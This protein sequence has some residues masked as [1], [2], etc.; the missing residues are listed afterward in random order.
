MDALGDFGSFPQFVVSVVILDD[1]GGLFSRNKAFKKE[2]GENIGFELSEVAHVIR[3]FFFDIPQME[4]T[5]RS[6][7]KGPNAIELRIKGLAA[8]GSESFFLRRV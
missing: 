3:C 4:R 1:A 7:G 2:N 6:G 8:V 5:G